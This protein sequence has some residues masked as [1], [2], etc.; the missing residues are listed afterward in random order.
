MQYTFLNTMELLNNI[1]TAAYFPIF[2]L[3]DFLSPTGND[4]TI[5]SV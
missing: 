3:I 2:T 4:S 1:K 5:K